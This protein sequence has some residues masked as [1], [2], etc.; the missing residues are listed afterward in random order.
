MDVIR[1]AGTPV[2][3]SAGVTL[4]AVLLFGVL[5]SLLAARG[6]LASL[7]R[8]DSR[9][10][11]ETRGGHGFRQRLVASQMALAVVMLAGAG[12]LVGSLQRRDRV[13]LALVDGRPSIH[14]L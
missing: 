13:D 12:L 6:D 2:G 8:L 1:L 5:P 3:V 14:R 11:T 9:S 4:L 7:L 10:G